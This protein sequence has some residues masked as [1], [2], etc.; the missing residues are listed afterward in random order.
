M[1]TFTTRD[2]AAIAAV[3]RELSLP[4]AAN[5]RAS[6]T[7]REI[8]AALQRAGICGLIHDGTRAMPWKPTEPG[9]SDPWNNAD[10]RG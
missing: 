4:D 7:T 1:F 10:C 5:S 2:Y 9:P 6:I 8:A 3:L